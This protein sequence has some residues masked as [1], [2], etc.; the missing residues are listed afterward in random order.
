MYEHVFTPDNRAFGFTYSNTDVTQK[1]IQT[2]Y[3]AEIV[4]KSCE[5][6]FADD[7]HYISL[8]FKGPLST[9][10]TVES[11]AAIDTKNKK[12]INY[13]IWGK[14]FIDANKIKRFILGVLI[15]THLYL[16]DKH[17]SLLL[18][19]DHFSKVVQSYIE[20]NNFSSYPILIF[21]GDTE[22]SKF[23]VLPFPMRPKGGL[24]KGHFIYCFLA[25]GYY[26]NVIVSNHKKPEKLE[27][28]ML[29][30]EQDMHILSGDLRYYFPELN[31]VL[32]KLRSAAKK[33][34]FTY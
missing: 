5:K 25:Y 30:K 11:L 19:K 1:K 33:S 2:G 26:F 22:L 12:L 13:E 16:R 29:K 4:C 9:A 23:C 21:K 32:G 10:K 15:R 28:I 3:Y 20:A 34:G 8:L 7:D 14:E 27:E 31:D 24:L 6:F 18:K 17:N